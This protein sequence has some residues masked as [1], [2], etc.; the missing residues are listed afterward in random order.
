VHQSQVSCCLRHAEKIV[1]GKG[2]VGEH[3]TTGA[4]R[5]V[6]WTLAR[7]VMLSLGFGATEEQEAIARGAGENR[8]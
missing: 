8:S 7:V 1:A 6:L 2:H 3:A 5:M 4:M